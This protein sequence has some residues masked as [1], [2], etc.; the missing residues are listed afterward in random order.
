M[1]EHRLTRSEFIETGHFVSENP[2]SVNFASDI[3]KNFPALKVLTHGT[4]P[5][6]YR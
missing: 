2:E 6:A 5:F 3:Q 4:R 1:T